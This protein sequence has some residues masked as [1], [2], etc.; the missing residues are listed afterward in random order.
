MIMS[1]R[2]LNAGHFKCPGA[3]TFVHL[4]YAPFVLR[5]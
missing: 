4:P 1:V 3:D 2:L 5:T